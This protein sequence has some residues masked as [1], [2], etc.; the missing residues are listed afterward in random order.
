MALYKDLIETKTNQLIPVLANGKT[1]ESRYN[2]ENEAN[3]AVIE[4]KDDT[5]FLLILGIAGGNLINAYLN[6]Y[7]E[8]FVLGIE[9]NN[10]DLEFLKKIPQIQELLENKRFAATS[11]DNLSEK[12]ISA[13]VPSVHGNISIVENHVWCQENPESKDEI[14]DIFKN[15]IKQISADF[16]VQ[17][18][19]GKIWQDNIIKNLISFN[20]I[21]NS[22]I[23][24]PDVSKTAVIIAAG[25]TLDSKISFIQ[26][27]RKD[28][29]IISTDT[30]FSTMLKNNI[31]SDYVV[32]IDGQSISSTHFIH[33]NSDFSK[34][35][36]IF[37]LCANHSAVESLLKKNGNIIFANTGHPLSEFI[38]N[39]ANA[40]LMKLY[41]GSGTVTIAAL[42]FA[43]KTGFKIINVIGADFSYSK[44]KPYAKGTYLDQIYGEKSSKFESLEKQFS[45]LMYRTPLINISDTKFTTEVLN[46]YKISFEN[47]LESCNCTYTKNSDIYE[48]CSERITDERAFKKGMPVDLDDFFKLFEN[49]YINF[50]KKDND[51]SIF[52]LTNE[53]ICFLPLISWLRNYENINNRKFKD[54]LNI[55]YQNILRYKHI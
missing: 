22:K 15:T 16:S 34:T 39:K 1:V 18:H 14:I 37:D 51:F 52:S 11:I 35:T 30:A 17:A 19:F 24:S 45:K 23:Q 4:L 46:S 44:G 12:M 8:L 43:I 13:Y 3:R 25:P 20:E 40:D 29:C 27:N 49:S 38:S 42:D 33:N 48:I 26:D 2:P 9:Q 50:Q 7:P 21:S 31:E 5:G 6:K 53:E 32:S 55:S 10:E 28:F 36:F 47:Y 54:Y 41:S